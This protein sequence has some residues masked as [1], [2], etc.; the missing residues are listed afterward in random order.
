VFGYGSSAGDYILDVTCEEPPPPPVN[1]ECDA[2]TVITANA[3]DS[4]TEFASGTV[5]GAT[6]SGQDN[7]CF[8]TADDDVWYQFTAVG[9]DHAIT[10]FNVEGD[11]TDLYHSL[12]E[13]DD[14]GNLTEL[15]CSDPNDSVANG[16]TVGNTYYVRVF[17]WTSSP[18]QDVS[19]DICVF[20]IYSPNSSDSASI[21]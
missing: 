18:L 1:D 13:G 4:C 8:G 14:C 21:V 20:T 15:Y 2:A 19:F 3:D 11:T 10:L 12:Y 17:T 9:E 5:F 16:L 6:P 7:G